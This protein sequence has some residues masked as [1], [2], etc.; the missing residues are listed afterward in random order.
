MDNEKIYR[1][2][3]L[4]L[5]AAAKKAAERNYKGERLKGILSGLRIAEGLIREM[6]LAEEEDDG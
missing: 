4:S 2:K 6:E 1:D 5:L 3:A